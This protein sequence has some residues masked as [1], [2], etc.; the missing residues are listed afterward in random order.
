[1]KLRGVSRLFFGAVAAVLL[2]NLVLILVIRHAQQQTGEAVANAAKAHHQVDE[3]V[4]GTGLLASLVQSYTTTGRTHYLDLYYEILGVWRGELAPPAVDDPVAHWRERIAGRQIAAA[5]RAEQ[6]RGVIEQLRGQ[7]FTPEEL[8]VAQV[9]LDTTR[10]MQEVETIAFAA[11]QGLYDG[12]TQRFVD[13]GKPDRETAIQLVHA[14]HYEALRADL[15]AAV[16]RLSGLVQARVQAE[17]AHARRVLEVATL[18]ALAANLLAVPLLLAVSH[19][20]RWRV[21]RPIERL[22]DTATQLARGEYHARTPAQLGRVAELDTLGRTLDQMAGAIEADLQ[23]RDAVQAEVQRSREAAE[24]AARTKAAFLANMSHEIR[25]PMNAIMGMTELAL[26]GTLP[27]Q[28]RRWLEK[29]LAASRHLLGVINDVLD[30]SKVEAG[31]MTLEPAPLKVEELAARAL[32]LVRQPAQAKGLELLAEFED[33]SLLTQH[34]VLVGDALRLQQVLVNLLG[35]AVKFT[36]AGRVRL[37][38]GIDAAAAPQPGHVML[39]LAVSDTGIGMTDAQR[40]QLFR[41]FSQADDSITRRFGGTGLGL[42]I[43][44]RLVQ[45]MGGSIE[46][47]S[48]PGAGSCFT[49]RVPLPVAPAAA[50][51]ATAADAALA[52]C[53]VLVVEDRADTRATVV[54]LLQRM[55]VAQV[56]AVADAAAALQ[57]LQATGRA[58]PPFDLLLLDWVLDEGDAQDLLQHARRTWPQMRVLV[59]SAYGHAALAAQLERAGAALI[60]KP[61]LPQDLRRALQ[62]RPADAVAAPVERRLAGLRVLLVED[63]ALNREV[64]VGLLAVQG[65]QVAVAHHGLQ[66]LERLQ[67]DSAHAFD[68][69]LMD[70][71]MPVLDGA[72]TVK[73]LRAD[74]AFDTLPVLAMTAHAMAGERERC[75]DLG[76]QGY[77]SKPI[78]PEVLY[79]ELERWVP[80]AAAP[81]P[82]AEAVPPAAPALP[83]VPG[84]DAERLLAHCAG[85]T[86]LARRLLRGFA[87]D[88]AEGLAA[89]QAAL[90]AGDMPTLRRLA[91]TLQGLAGTLAIEGLRGAALAVE[92]AAAAGDA[93]R[94]AALLPPLDT[95]LAQVLVRLQAV[96]AEL[97]DAAPA[98]PAPA[99]APPLT[100][101]VEPDLAELAT[102]LADSDS[103]ALD[104][105]QAHQAALACTLQPQ[106]WRAAVACHRGL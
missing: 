86:A 16:Q 64:A 68:V 21:L 53:R 36:A 62:P 97:V 35:N 87:D 7:R 100:A 39:R 41:E 20:L 63:N 32:A 67:A 92:E 98:P 22:V 13:D 3:I 55:G 96:R 47:A 99:G 78:E 71:Q 52:A 59:S 76:M 4:T 15:D 102:L 91:H 77:I 56:A 40:G 105:W 5:A 44:Q 80:S 24:A 101:N 104:W 58:G 72:Q 27:E 84:I 29:S 57:Q 70:L 9:M 33:A 23:R 83:A 60:D 28:E 43:S 65:A 75:L 88:H 38:L 30:F 66:A 81:Q 11:T 14:P 74:P 46:V 42:A 51:P 93:A 61:L 73:R 89:W 45:L 2:I 106:A 94:A 49:L 82:V 10:A 31:G 1:L 95:L 25:T 19:G 50:Q 17:L 12:R 18:W 37:A 79:A 26:R 34:A 103:R 6:P 54:G 8:Q 90:Q 85:N 48:T 69:V